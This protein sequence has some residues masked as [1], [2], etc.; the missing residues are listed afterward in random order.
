MKLKSLLLFIYIFCF[1]SISNGQNQEHDIIS[2]PISIDREGLDFHGTENLILV[3]ENRN[4]PH[5]RKIAV[6]FFRFPAKEQTDLAPVFYLPGGPGVFINEK[7][8]YQYYGGDRAKAFTF[9]LQKLNQKRDVIVL[10]QRG[11]PNAPGFSI[12]NFKYRVELRTKETPFDLKAVAQCERTSIQE[13]IEKFEQEG[14]DIKGYDILNMVEDI[15]AVRNAFKMKNIAFVGTSFGSQWA[16][17]YIQKYPQ[18]VDRA[19]LSGIEPLDHGYDDPD[20]IWQVLETLELYALTDEHLASSLPKF[21]LLDQVKTIIERLEKEPQIVHI[22][23]P[24]EGIDEQVT[25][26]ADD[27][28]VNLLPSF[29]GNKQKQFEAWP[30]YI[31]EIYNGDYRL[32]AFSVLESLIGSDTEQLMPALVDNS[33]GI[34]KEREI[35]LNSRAS[36]RWLGDINL[37]DKTIRDVIPTTVV[38]DDFRAHV[39]HSIPI[40]M[41]QGNL[42]LSTPFANAQFLMDYLEN[43]HLVKVAGGSHAVLMELALNHP[44]KLSL[45]LEFMDV[46]FEKS[47]FSEIKKRIQ[48]EYKLSPLSFLP[49]SGKSLFEQVIA[50]F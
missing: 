14:V 29:V 18:L 35:L 42:D 2:N 21:S 43:G 44:E 41:I 50:D 45:L 16:L 36:K 4:N 39:K 30:K 47:S 3:P 33:L 34:S 48:K 1:Y 40:L 7:R 19:F 25:I 6:H 10:N 27:F 8:F 23:I 28:R 13:A 37:I 24:Q 49:A 17:A 32:L 22:S 15:E 9:L 38:N 5:C 11:N 20:G 26:G 31:S 12:S 46:D